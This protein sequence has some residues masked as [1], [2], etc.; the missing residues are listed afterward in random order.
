[1]AGMS[2]PKPAIVAMRLQRHF[3]IMPVHT[4]DGLMVIQGGHGSGN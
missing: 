1:M 4:N 3:F 2:E